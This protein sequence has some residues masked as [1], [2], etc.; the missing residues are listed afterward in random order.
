METNTYDPSVRNFKISLAVAAGIATFGIV[1]NIN[2]WTL[3]HNFN[4]SAE[5][6]ITTQTISAALVAEGP[7]QA[8]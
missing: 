4:K 1:A 8:P 2:G 6:T 5:A 3:S 7:H